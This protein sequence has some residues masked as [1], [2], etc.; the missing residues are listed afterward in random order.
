MLLAAEIVHKT[1]AALPENSTIMEV[2][3]IKDILW[4]GFTGQ[5]QHTVPVIS[6]SC[7]N[8]MHDTLV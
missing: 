5:A 2:M 4:E 7:L 3:R 1:A 6:E 8:L